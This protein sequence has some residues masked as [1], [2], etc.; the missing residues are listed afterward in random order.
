M[1]VVGLASMV[2]ASLSLA[3]WKSPVS[4]IKSSQV[5]LSYPADNLETLDPII[6]SGQILL[7][8]GTIF[9][10][11]FG[12]N[13]KNQVVPKIA[14]KWQTSDGGRVWTIWLRHNA[15]WSN[16]KP[17]T[18]EDFYYSGCTVQSTSAGTKLGT[19]SVSDFRRI[20]VDH[21]IISRSNRGFAIQ[22]RDEGSIEDVL[23]SHLMIHTRRFH[24]A[25]WGRS[26]PIFVTAR[27]RRQGERCGSVRNVRF[28]HILCQGENG[29]FLEGTADSYLE[30]MVFD[31]VGVTLEQTTKRPGGSYDL[32]PGVGASIRQQATAGFH[33]GYITGLTLRGMRIA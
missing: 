16:G 28:T 17:V 26:E 11:L 25:W 9:E 19:E 27:P 32:R 14:E 29:I 33:G 22:L 1:S 23:I 21:C 20:V 24:D 10:G 31:Q 5:T 3:A 2:L 12:Y 4:S 7:D 15:R 18:A 6:W 8:Q 30:E 13:Q